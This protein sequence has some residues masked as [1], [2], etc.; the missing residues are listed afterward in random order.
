MDS[1]NIQ[2]PNAYS[3]MIPCNGIILHRFSFQRAGV[4]HVSHV[5]HVSHDC[6]EVHTFRLQ[7]KLKVWKVWKVSMFPRVPSRKVWKKFEKYKGSYDTIVGFVFGYRKNIR[8]KNDFYCCSLRFVGWNASDTATRKS[9]WTNSWNASDSVT[10]DSAVTL[11]CHQ[12]YAKNMLFCVQNRWLPFI[13][14]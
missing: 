6:E 4:S 2:L 13:H 9:R 5:D 1:T 7:R 8:I 14:R 12:K 11:I 10:A 3:A